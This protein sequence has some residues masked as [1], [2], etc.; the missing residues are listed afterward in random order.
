LSALD[1]IKRNYP[2]VPLLGV[3]VVVIR[4]QEI[5]LVKRGQAPAK[6]EWSLPGGLVELGE[7]AA[8]A[9][10]REISEE[11][12]LVIRD[13]SLLDYF[14]FIDWSIKGIKYHFVVLEFRALYA[15][16]ELA[17]ADDSI[18]ARWIHTKDID[19]FPCS[20]QIKSIV[21]KAFGQY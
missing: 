17:A 14:E 20:V 9:A 11:C 21:R 5:V 4:D 3:G 15:G 13:I 18:E 12:R 19:A 8:D 2:Q 1:Q 6:G 7:K 16:G 10:A